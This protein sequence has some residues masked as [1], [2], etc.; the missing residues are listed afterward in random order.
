MEVKR[1]V[2]VSDK[3][4]RLL[5]EAENESKQILADAEQR[6]EKIMAEARDEARNLR[7]RAETGEAVD[8]TVKEAEKAA[9]EDAKKIQAE[10]DM[11]LQELGKI[12]PARFEEAVELVLKRVVPQ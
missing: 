6:A 9:A 10:Y 12:P 2:E 4:R 11:R 5:E 7:L 3:L 1:Y 8:E